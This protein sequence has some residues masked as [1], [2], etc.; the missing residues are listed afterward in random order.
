MLKSNKVYIFIT[1]DSFRKVKVNALN[2]LLNKRKTNSSDETEGVINM[3][4]YGFNQFH[5]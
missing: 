2:R 1:D 5:L 4:Y 3:T